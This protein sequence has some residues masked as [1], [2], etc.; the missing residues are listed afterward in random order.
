MSCVGRVGWNEKSKTQF[1][2]H[3]KIWLFVTLNNPHPFKTNIPVSSSAWS[4]LILHL[5]HPTMKRILT[6]FLDVK[7]KT[8]PILFHTFNLYLVLL[9][10]QGKI[11]KNK[12]KIPSG[13]VPHPDTL[14]L[15][16]HRY[17]QNI[18]FFT[19]IQLPLDCIYISQL[20]KH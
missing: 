5:S 16:L 13:S 9:S 11:M 6:Q 10:L 4:F 15:I 7:K 1:N 14:I 2:A 20:S 19:A 3:L 8:K 17:L 18:T 12:K